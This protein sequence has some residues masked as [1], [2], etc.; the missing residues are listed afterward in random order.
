MA[1]LPDQKF[2]TFV[3]GGTLLVND[4]IVGLRGGLNTRFTYTG[5]LPP[6]VVVPIANG[7]TGATTATGARAN[8]GLGTMAVQNA[9]SVAIT[10]GTLDSVTLSNEVLGTPISGILTNC[11][12]LPVGTGLSLGTHSSVLVTNSS[13]VP[14]WSNTMTNGQ[15]IIGS[16]GATPTAS[17]L[18]A[19][20]GIS[21]VNGAASITINSTASG[22]TWSTVSGTSQSAAV[23]NGYIVNNAGAVTVTLP[24]TAAIGS[25]IAVEGLG[26][27]GW[28]LT[29]NAGQTIKIGSATTSSAGSLSSVAIS[30][31]V[32]VT[33]IVANLT[34]RVRTTNSAGL[35]IS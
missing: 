30:D 12:G 4:I 17:T 3:D 19:G 26:A 23:D 6:G 11:T 21:I 35:T 31:N 24:A 27:G 16:T 29:A 5:A 18:T 33:C 34:W 15:L 2:S 8:L 7:G 10:G 20:T 14:A 28:I 25:E 32:Y 1:L 9:S 22:M 13:G